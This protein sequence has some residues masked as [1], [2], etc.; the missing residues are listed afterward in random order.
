MKNNL[1]IQ[2]AIETHEVV[3]EI[4]EPIFKLFELNFFRY[5]R[6]FPDGKRIHLCSNPHWTETFYT[7]QYYN[8]AWFDAVKL[9]QPKNI[10]AIWDKKAVRED[11][12]VGI[13]ART[14]FDIH[15][16]ISIVRP[17]NG[18]YEI[19][20]FA[21]NQNNGQINNVYLTHLHFFERFFFYFRE[22]AA[23]LIKDAEK[24]P[25][26]IEHLFKT[27]Y[28]LDKDNVSEFLKNTEIKHY[29]LSMLGKDVYLT[30]KETECV[31][32]SVLGKSA[33]EIS[34][35]VNCSKRTVEIHLESVKQK[36]GLS[37]ISQVIKLASDSGLIEAFRL[38][39]KTR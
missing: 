36:L 1:A 28:L 22:K 32:W 14:H 37:K 34:L 8:I 17:G 33:V 3:R 39:L 30:P 38:N 35:I 11:N 18:Y 31:Y 27:D 19:F 24:E 23:F 5:L 12:A 20:D 2:L 13:D 26:K 21:A 29:T 25:I 16:G 15:H 4:C 10:E 7:K 9:N 6:V